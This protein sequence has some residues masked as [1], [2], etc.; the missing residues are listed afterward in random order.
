MSALG[1]FSRD[2]VQSKDFD[3]IV[4][5]ERKGTALVRSAIE[6][7]SP[8]AWQKVISS[9]ALP[10]VGRALKNARI[11]VFDDS[12]W[13][14]QSLRKA[15]ELI[16]KTEE[17]ARIT[18]AAFMSHRRAPEE[19]LDIV[20]YRALDDDDY[21]EIR[22]AIVEYLQY[23]GSLLLDTEHLEV[24]M[25]VTSPLSETFD[26]MA[27]WGEAVLFPSTAQRVNCTIVQ[28]AAAFRERFAQVS[29]RFA[30]LDHAVCK[31]RVITQP[32]NPHKFN[33]I[34][35][36]YPPLDLGPDQHYKHPRMSWTEKVTG[37]KRLFH[38]VGL[39]LS[40]ELLLDF[41]SWMKASLPDRVEFAYQSGLGHLQ[42][43]FPEIDLAEMVR[44]LEP[45]RKLSKPRAI[46]P[47]HVDDKG[48]ENIRRL[49]GELLQS[50][51]DPALWQRDCLKELTLD[52]V[53]NVAKL[54]GQ[55]FARA[56]AAMDLLI[57]AA[58]MLPGIRLTRHGDSVHAERVFGPDGEIVRRQVIQEALL[59][60][61]GLELAA[62]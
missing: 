39:S 23:Q 8:A 6:S 22:E 4:P 31:M 29:P 19:L 60:G 62:F 20:Y 53:I 54:S 26:A 3:Y 32:E 28:Q 38:C 49:A 25:A 21:G 61:K 40:T 27:G 10:A 11:L 17:T 42:P 7:E 13:R 33:I 44:E 12:V 56:S 18:T 14:G 47:G 36:C 24:E 15:V 1:Q 52:E 58:R 51:Y 50:C 9:Q 55:P 43:V 46:R 57:D 34:P 59:S 5:I 48:Y 16:R 30:Q 2:L 37:E 41:A 35:I 45:L